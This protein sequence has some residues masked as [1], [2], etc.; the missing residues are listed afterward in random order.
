MIR[1]SATIALATVFGLGVVA[2]ATAPAVAAEK[3]ITITVSEAAVATPNSKVCMPKK[4]VGR[5]KD[6]SAP[7]TICQTRAEWEAQ[8]V[9]VNVKAK[10]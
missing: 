8:G 9:V 4:M 10:S 1:Q 3:P 2:F 7:A 6:K 5:A